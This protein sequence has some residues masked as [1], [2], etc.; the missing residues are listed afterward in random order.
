MRCMRSSR[1]EGSSNTSLSDCTPL[2]DNWRLPRTGDLRTRTAV[3]GTAAALLLAFLV[4][5]CGSQAPSPSKIAE[6]AAAT[7]CDNSGFYIESQLTGK[8]S[9]VYDCRFPSKMPECVT[10]SS[11]IAS[12]ATADVELLFANALNRTKPRCLTDLA[13]AKERAAHLAA[14]RLAAREAKRAKAY[15][16][17]L[18]RSAK[19]T[20]HQGY[21]PYWT[22]VASYSLPTIYWRWKSGG[23]ASYET[24]CW[25]VDVITRQG[26][27][28][29][30]GVQA[31]VYDHRGGSVVDN[32]LGNDG[33][34]VP[35]L[36]PAAVEMDDPN[37]TTY[38]PSLVADDVTI[39]CD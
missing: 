20:W 34:G 25:H 12:D 10:Y 7:T 39:Q 33:N 19:E 35:P 31:N 11:G 9:T 14:K 21:I 37:V 8:K 18:D 1:R 32:I 22:G 15:A 28:T 30:L 4:S 29:Y 5:A 3:L 24:E 27:P 6:V 23:C 36:T 26:C 16:S 17:A 38:D 13:A 2:V